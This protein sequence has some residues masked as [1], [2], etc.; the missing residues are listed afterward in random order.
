MKNLHRRV[1]VVAAAAVLGVLSMVPFAP[2]AD[3]KCVWVAIAADGSGGV[4]SL[5]TP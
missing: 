3:A 2:H 4:H 1:V 5:C